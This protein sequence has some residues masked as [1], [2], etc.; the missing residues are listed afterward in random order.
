MEAVGGLGRQGAVRKRKDEV[1]EMNGHKFVQKQFYQLILCAF[2]NEFLLNALG[3]QC[4]DCRYTCHK[5]CY[6][7]VV[8]KCIS[9]SNTGVCLYLHGSHLYSLRMRRTMMKRRLIIVFLIDSNLSPIWARIGAVIVDTCFLLVAKMR[10]NVPNAISLVMHTVLTWFPTSVVCRWRLP[11]DCSVIG[12]ISTR[13]VRTKLPSK[14]QE[15]RCNLQFRTRF[16]M[17]WVACGSLDLVSQKFLPFSRHKVLLRT[18]PV[19]LNAIRSSRCL[20]HI[21]RL[22]DNL[23]YQKPQLQRCLCHQRM[24]RSNNKAWQAVLDLRMMKV[25]C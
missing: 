12:E 19:L 9:K 10:E 4:E 24:F 6:E 22:M 18:D 14:P 16:L 21:L 11:I 8:T 13:F 1:H 5:K 23:L 2:C 3:Y 7:K 25:A 20:G 15:F 17:L